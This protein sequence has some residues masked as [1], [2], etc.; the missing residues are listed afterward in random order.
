M[1]FNAPDHPVLDVPLTDVLRADIALP[2][3]QLLRI[4]T[5][6]SLLRAWSDP[7]SQMQIRNLFDSAEHAQLAVSL[8][9]TWAGW[10][11]SA[12]LASDAIG[13]MNTN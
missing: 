10:T 9:A 8:C 5:I 1:P 3:Q 12:L 2:I 4:Y 11:N 7:L 6:G 13:W